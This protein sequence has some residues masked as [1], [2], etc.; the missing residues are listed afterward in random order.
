MSG[1]TDGVLCVKQTMVHRA[2]VVN[3]VDGE[4]NRDDSNKT[5]NYSLCLHFK[6]L[7]VF[8]GKNVPERKYQSRAFLDMSFLLPIFR[9]TGRQMSRLSKPATSTAS[10]SFITITSRMAQNPKLDSENISKITDAEKE[11]TASDKPIKSGPTA[12]AQ[13]H[14]GEPIN[15]QTLSDIT[16][17]EKKITGGKF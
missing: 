1:Y 11:I 4:Q 12:Q 7:C 8:D 5:C 3:N 13:R 17:G 16:K 10:R 15:S 14:A 6:I 9:Q 2:R